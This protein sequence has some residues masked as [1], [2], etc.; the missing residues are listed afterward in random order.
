MSLIYALLTIVSMTAFLSYIILYAHDRAKSL[1]FRQQA[2]MTFFLIMM[3][4]MLNSLTFYVAAPST[5][6]NSVISSSISMLAMSVTVLVLILQRMLRPSIKGFTNR[7]VLSFAILLLYNEISMGAFVYALIYGFQAISWHSWLFGILDIMSLSI[8]SYLFIVPM[9]VEMV[10]LFI[11]RS[12]QKHKRTIL[13]SILILSVASP[14]MLRDPVWYDFV[15][16]IDVII[17]TFIIPMIFFKNL[18]DTTFSP[19][20]EADGDNFHILPVLLLMMGGLLFGYFST[21]P[22]EIAWMIYGAGMAWMML[23]YFTYSIG[24]KEIRS[25]RERH[26]LKPDEVAS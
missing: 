14:T 3:G 20:D 10:V 9:V 2:S 23:F 17:M 15:A 18:P 25:H 4:S 22:F 12:P 1:T 8:N 19:G 26:P 7:S 21:Q 6:L 16:I 11:L 5:F 24:V 13:I